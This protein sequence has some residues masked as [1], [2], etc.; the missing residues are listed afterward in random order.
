MESKTQRQSAIIAGLSIVIMTIAAGVANDVTIGPLIVQDSDPETLKNILGAK[1]TFNLGVLCWLIIL[2]SD[3]FAA[4]G[5]Y[6]FL[7][8][9]NKNLSLITGWFRIVYAAML[10]TSIFNLVYV[11]LLISDVGKS[12]I[13]ITGNLSTNVMFFLDAFDK[14]FSVSLIVF[15]IHILLLGY[16]VFRSGYVPKILGILLFIG[17]IGYMIINISNL[18]IPQYKDFIEI[19]N[20][21]FI[22][23]MLAEVALGLWLLIVGLRNKK[24]K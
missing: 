13:G 15:G 2:A 21:I 11:S 18:L 10:A 9:V 16:L 8:P 23:P 3:V 14:M 7:K 6:L 12:S 4:W 22:I 17:F 24:I 1:L 20:W 5:L 19:L